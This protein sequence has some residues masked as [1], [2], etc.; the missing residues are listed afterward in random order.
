MFK[1]GIVGCGFIAGAFDDPK[2]PGVQSHAKAFRRNRAFSELGFVD[3]DPRRARTLASRYSGRA[4]ASVDAMLSGLKPDVVS[5]CVP[6]GAHFAVLK[7][8]LEHADRPR[9]VFA[10]KPVCRDARELAVLR[11]LEA[12]TGAAVLVNH[13]RRFDKAHRRVRELVRSGTLGALIGGHADYY[14]GFRHLGV[15][16]VDFL[17]FAFD[18]RFTAEGLRYRCASKYADDPTLDGALRAGRAAITLSGVPEK[19]YQIF[20]LSLL[21]EKGQVRITDF[22][23]RIDVLRKTVNAAGENVLAPDARLSGPGLDSPLAEAAR[24]IAAYLRK[25]DRSLIAD[26]GLAEAAKTMDTLWK[27]SE[28]Y[29]SEA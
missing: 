15:H 24:V 16:L 1:A 28:L 19:N 9:V 18:R 10:E 27:G 12:R 5:V 13:T 6:D 20:D 29:D 14:G 7:R 25:E 26:F 4:F 8:V 2:G 17:Q 21:F 11:R 22:G 23:G 3:R